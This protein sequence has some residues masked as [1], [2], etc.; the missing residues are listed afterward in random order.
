M[1]DVTAPP[2]EGN[3]WVQGSGTTDGSGFVRIAGIALGAAERAVKVEALVI[4]DQGNAWSAR[5]V[6]EVN[7]DDGEFHMFA[8]SDD[9]ARITLTTERNRLD[10]NVCGYSGEVHWRGYISLDTRIL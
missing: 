3:T 8:T 5:A 7:P 9:D 1:A 4:D 2:G 10:L 6:G